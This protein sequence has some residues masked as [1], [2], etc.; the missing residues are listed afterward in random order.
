MS[1]VKSGNDPSNFDNA[2]RAFDSLDGKKQTELKEALAEE[3][4]MHVHKK[5][6]VMGFIGMNLQKK[7]LGAQR[8]L[9]KMKNNVIDVFTAHVDEF[10]RHC[11]NN[12]VC[13]FHD[14]DEHAPMCYKKNCAVC[15]PSLLHQDYV[16]K[17]HIM[18]VLC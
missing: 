11:L 1:N 5:G 3:M 7:N 6:G 17:T 8:E 13:H 16:R 9:R 14:L 4:S 2:C 15:L 12:V 10:N 18:C